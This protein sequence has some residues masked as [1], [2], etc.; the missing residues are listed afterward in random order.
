MEK[1]NFTWL[2]KKFE[3]TIAL[4]RKSD[5]L[6]TFVS[7]TRDL[8]GGDTRSVGRR[9]EMGQ[10]DWLEICCD[11]IENRLLAGLPHWL[12]GTGL[13]WESVTTKEVRKVIDGMSTVDVSNTH[14]RML[15]AAANGCSML[16]DEV[17]HV[18]PEQMLKIM[19]RRDEEGEIRL[20]GGYV[21]PAVTIGKCSC[22]TSDH[23]LHLLSAL[24]GATKARKGIQSDFFES[25]DVLN[26]KQRLTAFESLKASF[27]TGTRVE[28]IIKGKKRSV[29]GNKPSRLALMALE[30]AVSA[31]AALVEMMEAEAPNLLSA[32]VWEK[33]VVIMTVAVPKLIMTKQGPVSEFSLHPVCKNC[34]INLSSGSKR[35]KMTLRNIR[36]IARYMSPG[37]NLK[38]QAKD[39]HQARSQVEDH[40]RTVNDFT[41][42]IQSKLTVMDR[43]Q[44]NKG[45]MSSPA[46]VKNAFTKDKS[47]EQE[48]CK[49]LIEVLGPQDAAKLVKTS[50]Q[51]KQTIYTLKVSY[52]EAKQVFN[53]HSST[54]NSG[55]VGLGSID[56]PV[57]EEE[58]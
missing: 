45:I 52:A 58:E 5:T 46:Q 42:V 25:A 28:K 44:G 7:S 2:G 17:R 11:T 8:F 30:D 24:M 31:E 56:S 35:S 40:C 22:C 18:D 34:I 41:N 19:T 6:D 32:L 49:S 55:L 38:G 1:V 27:L 48:V 16:P 12:K 33:S 43:V 29:T 50:K 23:R 9:Q 14:L 26:R 36:T 13:D 4:D 20:T 54:Q 37:L 21:L 53:L 39:I 57:R 10:P 51:G 3:R 15:T 47:H